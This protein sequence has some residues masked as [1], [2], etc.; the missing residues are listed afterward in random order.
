MLKLSQ[1]HPHKLRLRRAKPLA[2][3]LLGVY[4]QLR[5]TTKKEKAA[6]FFRKPPPKICNAILTCLIL[7]TKID[8]HY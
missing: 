6:T 5:H 1:N 3:V 4:V 8:Q 7:L 2:R